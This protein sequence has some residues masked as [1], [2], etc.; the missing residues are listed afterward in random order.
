MERAQRAGEMFKQKLTV[1]L[2]GK[3]T[4][5]PLVRVSLQY[6][7]GGVGYGLIEVI[8]R[9]YTHPSMVITGGFCFAMICAVNRRFAARSLL[10]RSIVCTLGVTLAEFCVG[11]LVNRVLQM[12]VWDY[13]GKWMHLLGQICPLYMIFWF[14]LCFSLS[15]LLQRIR[16]SV[17]SLN[18]QK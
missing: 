10:F 12:H 4:K 18:L 11:M 15:F 16:I 2:G 13:S 17:I 5:N 14:G 8:W 7:F 1:F 9:G 3:L 6:L